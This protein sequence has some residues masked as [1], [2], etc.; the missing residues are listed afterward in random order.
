MVGMVKARVYQN[1]KNHQL[2]VILPKSKLN[3]LRDKPI[4]KFLRV[5][6]EDFEYGD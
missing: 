1:K 5:K 4:P 3:F 6:E 2:A